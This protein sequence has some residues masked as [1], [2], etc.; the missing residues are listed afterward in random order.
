MSQTP[1]DNYDDSRQL[2][3][4][5]TISTNWGT[6]KSDETHI[7][8]DLHPYHFSFTPISPEREI[9][10]KEIILTSSIAYSF[11]NWKITI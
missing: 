6:L 3:F 7:S 8:Q 11:I 10:V 2:D 9:W 5:S 1:N 4:H